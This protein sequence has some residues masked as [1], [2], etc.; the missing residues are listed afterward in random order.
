M[1]VFIKSEC[2]NADYKPV[3]L[4]LYAVIRIIHYVHTDLI[5]KVYL[6]RTGRVFWGYL[7][8]KNNNNKKKI[9]LESERNRI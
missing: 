8:N 6:I 5:F 1:F 9:I 3:T 7:S 2:N 4:V